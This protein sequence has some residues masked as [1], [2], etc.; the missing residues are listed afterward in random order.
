MH[1][2][3][4][5]LLAGTA[6]AALAS[7]TDSATSPR[8]APRTPSP[9]APVFDFSATTYSLG[10]TQ[11]DFSVSSSGGSFSIGGL[12]TISFPA[13]SV[14]D[15]ARS[16]YGATEWDNDCVLLDQGQ[17]V[18]IHATLVLSAY[19][20][21][22]DFSPALR[23]SPNA[24]VTISTDLF[25]SVIKANQDYFARNTSALNSLAILY[26]SDL[27]Q[28]GVSDYARDKS[29]ATHVNLNTGRI[30]R[31]VKHF[32]GYSIISGQACDPSPDNPDCVWVDDKQ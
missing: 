27:G 6:V 11:S 8:T 14:C 16:T 30:W 24:S 19:G 15:P 3:V 32:S 31:R 29:V 26:S 23:F 28:S 25:A 2:S 22:V 4:R 1:A 7:C 13:N 20:L 5:W 21:A 17:S 9:T 12:Y 10:F 18:K